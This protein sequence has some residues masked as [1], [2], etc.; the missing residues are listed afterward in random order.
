MSIESDYFMNMDTTPYQ[1]E[2]VAIS[3]K[4]VVAHSRSFKDVHKMVA[5]IMDPS[6][7]LFAPVSNADS[8]IL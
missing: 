2:W 7:V 3:G 5:D 1:G 4:R 6:S 8:L